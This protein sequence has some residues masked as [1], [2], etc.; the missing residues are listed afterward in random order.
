MK[1]KTPKVILYSQRAKCLLMENG[2]NG[3][4]EILFYSGWKMVRTSTNLTVTEASGLTSTYGI[5]QDNEVNLDR[6]NQRDMWLHFKECM[7]HCERIE[8]TINQLATLSA[9]SNLPLFPLTIGRRP[10]PATTSGRTS[11]NITN[12]SNNKEN[13]ILEPVLLGLKSFDGSVRGSIGSSKMPSLRR[14]DSQLSTVSQTVDVPGIGRAVRKSTGD[15]EVFFV[16]GSR[17]GIAP[18]SSTVLFSASSQSNV[19]IF[20]AKEALPEEVR[21]KLSLVP[22]VVEQLVQLSDRDNPALTSRLT[23]V[24]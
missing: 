4:F 24:R 18:N 7:A 13:Q 8:T 5:G 6:E 21:T 9:G 12:G 14:S 1:A 16:D 11:T 15:V 19:E 10:A 17:I 23:S 3:D 22:K 2:P 20:N